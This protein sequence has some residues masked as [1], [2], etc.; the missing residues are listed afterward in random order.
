MGNRRP[1]TD[2]VSLASGGGQGQRQRGW[3]ECKGL[4]A[5]LA[6]SFCLHLNE[7]F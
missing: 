1:K 2:S 6:V 5:R 7:E 4:V 3:L